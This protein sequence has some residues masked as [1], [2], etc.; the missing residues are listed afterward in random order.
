MTLDLCI[1]QLQVLYFGAVEP[2]YNEHTEISNIIH[3]ISNTDL[4][5]AEPVHN[6]MLPLLLVSFS[7]LVTSL[8][9]V[10]NLGSCI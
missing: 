8:V 10:V 3:P 1:L 6:L 5:H 4:L 7:Y 2:L 9:G